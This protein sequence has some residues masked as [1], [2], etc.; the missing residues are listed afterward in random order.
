MGRNLTQRGHQHSSHVRLFCVILLSL[1][2]LTASSLLRAQSTRPGMGSIPY[3]GATGTGVTFRVW[4]PNATSVAVP[5]SFNGW[6]PTANFLV[7]E[8]DSSLW[9]ADLPA[10]RAGHE[11]KYLI[12]GSHWWKD[13]RSRK[14]TA[15]GYDS[16]GANSIIYDPSAFN[17]MSDSRLSVNSSNLVIYEMHVGSFYDP[18]PATG[19]P[20]KFTNAVAKLDYL[21]GLGINA[22]ELL[23]LAE[24]PAQPQL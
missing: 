13:P 1:A 9:S 2:G 23:P 8:A 18:T 22:V 15:S 21:A 20:G 19:G 24:F 14:V 3:A 17:W 12:N 16:P 6:N 10:A 4:A 7:K 11:Y 5:G